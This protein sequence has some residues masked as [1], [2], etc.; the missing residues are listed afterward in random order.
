[1]GK[2]NISEGFYLIV[3]PKG[4]GLVSTSESPEG[5][6]EM[7]ESISSRYDNK[8]EICVVPG[9]HDEFYDSQ[10]IY[11]LVESEEV[12]FR[13]NGTLRPWLPAEN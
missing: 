2:G 4:E 11:Q 8:T 12:I 7:A 6:R 3:V 1:M 5:A 10:R 9:N 13:T